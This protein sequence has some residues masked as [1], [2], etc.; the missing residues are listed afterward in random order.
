MHYTSKIILSTISFTLLLYFLNLVTLHS[1]EYSQALFL[2]L[3]PLEQIFITF[4]ILAIIVLF[5]L[6]IVEKKNKD[7]VGMVFLIA[8]SIQIGVLYFIFRKVI[9]SSN[10][11]TI[12]RINFFVLFFLFLTFE[13]LIIIQLLNKKQ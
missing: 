1:L 2:Y 6:H 4:S 13:T 9:S 3:F 5:V 7:I 10:L 11:N 12:E 8:S